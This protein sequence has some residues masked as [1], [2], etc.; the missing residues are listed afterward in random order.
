[1]P[2]VGRDAPGPSRRIPAWLERLALL[3]RTPRAKRPPRPP[4]PPKRGRWW[5]WLLILI[6]VLAG[7]YV[8]APYVALGVAHRWLPL[9][10]DRATVDEVRPSAAAG[11]VHV[12]LF[13]GPG[14]ARRVLVEAV[15][16]VWLPPWMLR[17]GMCAEG[18]VDAGEDEPV[19]LTWRAVISGTEPRPTLLLRATDRDLQ[20]LLKPHAEMEMG[21][22]SAAWRISRA[23]ISHET[24]EEGATPSWTLKIDAAGGVRI[25]VGEAA[26]EI[27]IDRLIARL[28]V[29]FLPEDSMQGGRTTRWLKP[30]AT[31]KIESIESA[32]DEGDMLAAPST[33][34][35]LEAMVDAE[36]RRE[37]KDVRLPGWFPT[38]AVLIGDVGPG[39]MR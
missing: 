16:G 29:R 28:Y 31:L 36:M 27:P 32:G 35:Q 13:V 12:A 22:M 10:V 25:A 21:A 11:A 34:R 39:A 26:G 23:T 24:R 33:R 7:M 15:P 3:D 17:S 2:D 18:T 5:K 9:T 20:R 37:L 4:P 1:M 30:V 6:A 19:R 8:A 14:R 38:D